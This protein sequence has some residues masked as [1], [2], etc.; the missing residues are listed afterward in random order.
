MASELV[1]CLDDLRHFGDRSYIQ[2]RDYGNL[3]ILRLFNAQPGLNA[4]SVQILLGVWGPII[5]SIGNLL[6]TVMVFA[7][8]VVFGSG[9][10]VV[11]FWNFMGSVAIVAAFGVLAED[12]IIRR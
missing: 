7:S 8:D 9:I 6:N 4:H 5:T 11:T 1:C 3:L 10:E 2:C 12:L